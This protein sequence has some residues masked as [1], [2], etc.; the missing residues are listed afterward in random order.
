MISL[1]GP[2]WIESPED[3]ARSRI[4][5]VEDYVRAEIAAALE[6]GLVLVPVLVGGAKMPKPE[7]LP[8]DIRPLAFRNAFSLSGDFDGDVKNLAASFRRLGVSHRGKAIIL[9]ILSLNFVFELYSFG[10]KI[11]DAGHFDKMFMIRIVIVF[12]LSVFTYIGV[13]WAS[14]IFIT[15]SGIAALV[16]LSLLYDAFASG[17]IPTGSLAT[18]VLAVPLS[19]QVATIMC[20]TRSPSVERFLAEQRERYFYEK[21]H[22]AAPF[23]LRKSPSGKS[24][25]DK[26]T[27]DMLKSLEDGDLDKR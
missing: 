12:L 11:I 8:V 16:E 6:N 5:Q 13:R 1:I 21:I 25:L 4:H 15:L 26:L 17:G 20:L 2:T 23:T 24:E 27:L 18:L 22:T 10:N 19:L 9:M 3:P 14:A 7:A